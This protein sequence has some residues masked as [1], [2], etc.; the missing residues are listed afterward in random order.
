MQLDQALA[1]IEARHGKRR[2]L[3]RPVPRPLLERV[4]AAAAHA[5]SSRNLQPWRVTVVTGAARD[6]LSRRLVEA[7]DR[8]E[9]PRPDYLNSPPDDELPEEWARR[10]KAA[11]AGLFAA[12]G[13]DRGD[14][15]ARRLHTRENYL[16][17]GAPVEMIFHLPPPQAPGSF[18]ALGLFLEN[19]MLALVA[20]GLGSCPQYSV[21]GYA[22]VVRGHL[23]LPAGT[24][25][26]C[27]LAVGHPD[28][29][30]AVNRFHP[31]RLPL[32]EYAHFVE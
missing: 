20:A 13:V 18:L 4:L 25:V 10:A 5:P 6:E 28:P 22:D 3:D 24:V 17:F 23:G 29:Q 12:Q 9:P 2:Y 14:P 30:A 11:G 26:V 21:A 16:F 8:G 1:L 7:Y 32:G 27:G 31:E 19:V 15:E